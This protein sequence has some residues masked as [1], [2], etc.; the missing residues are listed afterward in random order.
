MITVSFHNG[1]VS[2]D[3][4]RAQ[5]AVFDS[6]GLEHLQLHTDLS[7]GQAIDDYLNNRYWNEIAIFDIDCIPLD[8]EVLNYAQEAVKRGLFGVAQAANHLTGK[9]YVGAPFVCFTRELWE[10]VGRTSFKETATE[11]V[12]GQFTRMVEKTDYLIEYLMPFHCETPLWNLEHLGVFGHGT[13]YQRGIY[14]AF[15]SRF[16]HG[17]TSRFIEK[18]KEVIDGKI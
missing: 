16:Q 13:T 15:E 2:G 1:N 10:A 4:V 18:C 7:H 14:H 5:K 6:H 3:L 8:K 12:G 11:D 17:S 9:M